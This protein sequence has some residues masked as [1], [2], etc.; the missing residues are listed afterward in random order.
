MKA[1]RVKNGLLIAV[2][3][4]SLLVVFI[5][6]LY[7]LNP[8]TSS[9]DQVD[10]SLAVKRFDIM[11]MQPH[12]PGYPFFILGG[13][14]LSLFVNDPSKALTLFNIL[15]Y[16]TALI[17][18][19][20]LNRTF[21]NRSFAALA[22][23]VIYSTSYTIIMVNQPMSE[24]AA[25]AAFWWYVWSLVFSLNRRNTT[26]ILLPLAFLSIMLGIRLSY[27]PFATG[28]IFLFFW[29]VKHEGMKI[30]EIFIYLLFGIVFQACWV[31]ALIIS[32]G[33]LLGFIKLSLAFTS[34]HFTDWGGTAEALDMS[35]FERFKLLV[36]DNIFWTGIF[37]QSIITSFIFMFFIAFIFIRSFNKHGKIRA[38][39][40]LYLFYILFFSYFVWALLAQN[41]EKARHSLPLIILIVF[42]LCI[43]LYFRK[44]PIL[45][46]WL[47]IFLLGS[48]V[49][50]DVSLLKEEAAEAPA[51]Y[52][53]NTYLEKVN[54]PILLYT[55][56]ETRVLQYLNAPYTHKRINTFEFFQSETKYFGSSTV[57][58]TDKVVQG[59]KS[60]GVLLDGK[61][62]KVAAFQSNELFDPVYNEIILYQ[63]ID[64]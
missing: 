55:W 44:V 10:F 18:I 32:E 29:K 57:Y 3:C 2:S 42:F 19:Y 64:K 54:Q 34:G 16:F 22:T 7:F 14:F 6:Q 28:V 43:Q 13:K 40:T 51:I 23:A 35:L 45:I 31:T 4:I 60:Q 11:A 26:A 53:M 63:W 21:I 27:I 15:F 52:Q 5:S 1:E 47:S 48:Q 41:I 62:K 36:W 8:Y 24:G 20:K 38:K 39:L 25:L 49:I 58:L 33:S 61:I 37:T 12:F 17:P 50:K 56:E 46:L 30:R 9:W 59:F